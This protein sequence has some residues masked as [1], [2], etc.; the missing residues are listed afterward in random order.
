ME[1]REV[2]GKLFESPNPR[3]FTYTNGP[4]PGSAGVSLKALRKLTRGFECRAYELER[5]A[6][7]KWVKKKGGREIPKKVIDNDLVVGGEPYG[8]S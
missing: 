7:D 2:V 8:Y 3:S 5:N 6:A 4:A 1:L